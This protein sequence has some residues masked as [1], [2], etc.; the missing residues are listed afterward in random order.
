MNLKRRAFPLQLKAAPDG[1]GRFTAYVS[2]FGTPD[3]YRE[4][5]A[6]TA[7]DASLA[8][9]AAAGRKIPI[10]WQHNLAEPIGVWDS[11]TPDEKGLLGV[12]DLWLDVAPYA[13]IAQRGMQ[14]GCITGASIGYFVTGDSFN[15]AE[16]VRTLTGIQLVEA[17]I[18]TDPAHDDARIDVVKAKLAAGE[19]PTEREFGKFL[20]EKGFA[21]SDA[22]AIASVGFKAWAAGAGRSPQAKDPAISSLIEAAGGYSLPTI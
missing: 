6:P 22:D 8:A 15:E 1:E 11:L 10:C 18:V 2:V 3:S 4:I 5:V 19:T 13:R 20:R 7:F 14:A 17:S 16:R 12:G 9:T 21:R